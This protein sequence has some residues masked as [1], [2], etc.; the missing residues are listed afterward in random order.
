MAWNSSNRPL[1]QIE[2]EANATMIRKFFVERLGWSVN[3]V[4]AMLA[5]MQAE[6]TI[7]PGRWES[8]EVMGDGN[9]VGLVQWTPWTK[10]YEWVEN[11][12]GSGTSPLDGNVQC[13][14]IKWEFEHHQQWIY[15]DW[16][17]IYDGEGN[18]I[19][20]QI[21]GMEWA[22]W[23]HSE[24][25]VYYLAQVFTTCYERPKEVWQPWRWEQAEKWL[26][27]LGGENWKGK[28]YWLYLYVANRR[29]KGSDKTIWKI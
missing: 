7:N 22:D 20:Y 19:G 11:T 25:D 15:V 24:L 1:T 16:G 12:Y 2:M 3:A 9:G 26:E 17:P 10:L 21:P 29:L 8:G 4:A 14:R 5:N 13:E 18:L 6:S 27:Y 28:A 23:I